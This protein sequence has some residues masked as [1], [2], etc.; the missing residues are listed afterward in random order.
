MRD[1]RKDEPSATQSGA[2]K[3]ARA[4]PT[5]PLGGGAFASP[6]AWAPSA[7]KR[8]RR[9][10]WITAVGLG[11]VA[12][13]SAG[14]V[15]VALLVGDQRAGAPSRARME[16][17]AE[18]PSEAR[19]SSAHSRIAKRATAPRA[20]VAKARATVTGSA[21]VQPTVQALPV[22]T[23]KREP[24]H[25]KARAD[26]TDRASAPA[27]PSELS[28]KQVVAAMRKITPAVNE[29]FGDTHGKAMATFSVVGKT[30]R[31]VGARVT[32]QTGKVGSCIARAVRRA[33][34]PKFA[35]PRLKVSYPFAN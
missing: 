6:L 17:R 4:E 25:R 1:T 21:A 27:L 20:P 35:G 14:I 26:R 31:V 13:V 33:R 18:P 28:R 15:A 23:V 34:F 30:G 2:T 8:S 24:A 32:G 9:H 16:L 29:C 22:T 7:E 10:Y 19:M 12:V 11:S 5:L 3:G